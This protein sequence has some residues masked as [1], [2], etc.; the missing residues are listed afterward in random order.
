MNFTKKEIETTGIKITAEENDQEIGRAFLYLI[1]NDLHDR[2][3][4]LLEDVLVHEDKRGQGIGEGLVKE[5]IKLAQEKN[6]YKLVGNSR[7][8]RESVHA[9]YKKLGFEEYGKEFRI[10]L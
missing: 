2:P 6:C 10:N 4:G 5:V 7:L 8:S 1:K 9:F 3:Y